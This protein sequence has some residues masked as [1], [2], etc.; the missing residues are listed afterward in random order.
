MGHA[1]SHP[2]DDDHWLSG[3]DNGT[4]MLMAAR[5]S[6]AQIFLPTGDNFILKRP[7]WIC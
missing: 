2:L 7:F 5:D 3:S 6:A 4:L 1:K